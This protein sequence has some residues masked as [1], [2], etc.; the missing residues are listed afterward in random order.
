VPLCINNRRRKSVHYVPDSL[1]LADMLIKLAGHAEDRM[2]ERTQYHPDMLIPIRQGLQGKQLPRGSHHVRLPDGGFVVVKDVGKRDKPRHV[3]ATVYSED[4]SP[5]GYDITYDVMDAQPEDVRVIKLLEGEGKR[6]GETYHAKQKRTPNSH[7]FTETKTLSSVK[8]ASIDIED[9][10]NRLRALQHDPDTLQQYVEQ[11][12]RE[13]KYLHV[14]PH[15]LPMIP[16]PSNDSDVT[17]G[18]VNQILSTMEKEP[19]SERFVDRASEHVNNVFYDVCEALNLDPLEQVAEDIA[20]DILKIAMYMKYKF[21]RPRPYQLAPYFEGNIQSSDMAAEESP[22]YPSG[23]SMMGFALSKLYAERY[24]E[25]ADKFMDLGR[26]VGLSR[27]QAG[28]HYPS[29]VVYAKKLTD[30]IM[31][32][33]PKVEKKA[34]L[35]GA[36]IGGYVAGGDAKQRAAGAAGGGVGGTVGGLTGLGVGIAA[37]RPLGLATELEG[38]TI[39]EIVKTPWK[40]TKALGGKGFGLVLG[41]NTIGAGVGGYVGGKMGANAY[42]KNSSSKLNTVRTP[43]LDKLARG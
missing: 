32:E 31:G 29:D 42:N 11:I 13:N 17:K 43:N 40:S 30:F 10:A 36:A 39:K 5:P 9:V 2:I 28:V 34:S 4:M 8:V 35:M 6:H 25:H 7:S 18:E 3:V 1:L 16:P 23:H 41:L 19:L 26:K 38:K 14:N 15:E 33:D 20:Q 22:S 27:I 21:L 12:R 24:P 37:A